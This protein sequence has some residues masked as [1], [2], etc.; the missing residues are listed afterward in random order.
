MKHSAWATAALA[1]AASVV[2]AACGSSTSSA[3]AAS[4]TTSS[5]AA[6]AGTSAAAAGKTLGCMVTDTG[7]RGRAGAAAARGDDHRR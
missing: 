4:G 6:G 5:P 2:I 3:P 7:G 1:V